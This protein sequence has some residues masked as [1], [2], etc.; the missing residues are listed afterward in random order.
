MWSSEI[1][2]NRKIDADALN[3]RRR[4]FCVRRTMYIYQR[5]RR[6]DAGN[7]ASVY[8][9]SSV[10]NKIENKTNLTDC[11]FNLTYTHPNLAKLNIGKTIYRTDGTSNLTQ[12][13][14]SSHKLTQT[15]QNST[16]DKL[17]YPTDQPNLT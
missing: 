13:N 4:R 8:G 2:I 3:R 1:H 9:I 10:N 16:S 6:Q 17:L 5:Q 7:C 14:L 12:P 11:T 15:L